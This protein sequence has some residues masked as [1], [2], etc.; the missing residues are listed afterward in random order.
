MEES[1]L[2]TSHDNPKVEAGWYKP[3]WKGDTEVKAK[4]S[5]AQTSQSLTQAGIRYA[6]I[7]Q[8]SQSLWV[9][10]Q[11]RAWC[12]EHFTT[13]RFSEHLRGQLTYESNYPS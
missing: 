4:S 8:S 12:M 6:T 10:K 13:M 2:V 1:A 3:D 5:Q 7:S 11:C 9:T